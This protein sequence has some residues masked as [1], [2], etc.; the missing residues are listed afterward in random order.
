MANKIAV[1]K[2]FMSFF[3]SL[4]RRA[5]GSAFATISQSRAALSAFVDCGRDRYLPLELGVFCDRASRNFS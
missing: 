4:N 5:A 1:W 3:S 2:I